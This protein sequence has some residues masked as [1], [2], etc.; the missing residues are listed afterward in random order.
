M[1]SRFIRA[2]RTQAMAGVPA[3]TT[4]GIPAPII[5]GHHDGEHHDWHG[6][7]HDWLN[8]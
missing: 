4:I 1:L 2:A 6:D 7:N 5:M 8:D 3:S